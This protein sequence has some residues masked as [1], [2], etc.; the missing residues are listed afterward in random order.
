M[1]ALL[2]GHSPECRPGLRG[3]SVSPEYGTGGPILKLEEQYWLPGLEQR[4]RANEH[5]T[6]IPISK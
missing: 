2:P 4:F 3:A 5:G 1:Q 6:P